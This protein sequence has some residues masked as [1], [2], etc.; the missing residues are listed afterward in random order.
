MC[1]RR[2]C[3]QRCSVRADGVVEPADGGA[4]ACGRLTATAERRCAAEQAASVVARVERGGSDRRRTPAPA[5]GL[6]PYDGGNDGVEATAA[7]TID[8]MNLTAEAY[9]LDGLHHHSNVN[10]AKAH[11][12]LGA[13]Q[14]IAE[15]NDTASLLTPASL[16]RG[17]LTAKVAAARAKT[18]AAG[19]SRRGAA[20][21]GGR[22]T[23]GQTQ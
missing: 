3:E 11:V 1:P 21:R 15:G 16:R 10:L 12:L 5:C 9:A 7:P 8:F 22:A 13:L 14:L 18:E 2:A 17:V 6:N 4:Q 20:N 19:K 23:S